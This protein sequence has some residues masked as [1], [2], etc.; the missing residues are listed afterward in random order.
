MGKVWGLAGSEVNPL[1]GVKQKDPNNKVERFLTPAETKR[2][3]Q[4]V[5]D[6]PNPML[7]PIVA[8]LL[9]T[10]CR[11]RELLD[12]TWDEF[13]LDQGFWRIPT[14]KSKTGKSRQV[15]LSES[16]IAV[17]KAIPRLGDCPYVVPNPATLKPFGSV[18][19][20]W[21]S[22]RNA[23]GLPDVRMHDLRHSMASNMANSG[24]SLLVIGQVLGHSQPRTTL[25][26][27]H[28]SE[29]TLQKA[30]N[31]ASAASG[32]SADAA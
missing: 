9:L 5:E 14:E 2:L 8:L 18:Y 25:R 7:A 4:A 22:A 17:L 20:S 32:W 12:A 10:G 29:G 30:A 1:E 26:Y 15:P 13:R 28:L 6:S 21:N 23:A 16:A 27:A 19:N 31:A 24:Q 3:R 11:K